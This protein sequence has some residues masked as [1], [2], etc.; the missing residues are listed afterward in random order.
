MERL[1]EAVALQS[2]DV[3]MIRPIAPKQYDLFPSLEAPPESSSETILDDS[4]LAREKDKLV[5]P[6]LAQDPEVPPQVLAILPLSTGSVL[7]P[8]RH[9]KKFPNLS[10]CKGEDGHEQIP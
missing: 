4:A 7:H 5:A 9:A 3:R 10:V 6:I 2:V 1:C 8:L